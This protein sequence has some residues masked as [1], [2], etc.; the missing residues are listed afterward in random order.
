MRI[1]LSK[2]ASDATKVQAIFGILDRA[3]LNPRQAVDVDVA[4]GIKQSPEDIYANVVLAST[5]PITGPKPADWDDALD[6][7]WEFFSGQAALP[8]P[9]V[10]DA[11][12]VETPAPVQRARETEMDDAERNAHRRERFLQEQRAERSTPTPPQPS[13]EDDPRDRQPVRSRDEA[14][15]KGRERFL[16]QREGLAPKKRHQRRA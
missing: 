8:D 5:V 2:T 16:V 1:A 10:I 4:V 3:G 12:I 6:G 13:I 14:L 9:N 15:T 7:S 11:E